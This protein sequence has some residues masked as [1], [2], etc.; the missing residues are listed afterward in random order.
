MNKIINF[1]K[2]NIKISDKFF[3][4]MK[5]NLDFEDRKDEL[6]IYGLVELISSIEKKIY[7]LNK[8]IEFNKS[9]E[10][11]KKLSLI[12][13]EILK[14]KKFIINF[15]DK[16][17]KKEINHKKMNSYVELGNQIIEMD[18][19]ELNQKMKD[20]SNG[21]D[22]PKEI[23]KCSNEKITNIISEKNN[24]DGLKYRNIDYNIE[25]G[26]YQSILNYLKDFCNKKELLSERMNMMKEEKEILKKKLIE[27]ISKKESIEESSKIILFKF[28]NEEINL[29]VKEKIKDNQQ[30]PNNFLSSNIKFSE[31]NLNINLYELYTININNL[32]QE[33]SNQVISFFNSFCLKTIINSKNTF[34]NS[35]FESNNSINNDIQSFIISMSLGIKKEFLLFINSFQNIDDKYKYVN[36]FQK[37]INQFLIKLSKNI[38]NFL[39]Y[40]TNEQISSNQEYS[41]LI[42]SLSDNS[43]LITYLKL[44]IKKNYI[45]RIIQEDTNFLNNKYK[46]IEDSIKNDLFVCKEK[47]KELSEK[48]NIFKSKLNELGLEMDTL[49]LEKSNKGINPNSKENIYLIL[50]EKTN[51]LLENKKALNNNFNDNINKCEKWNDTI[52]NIIL[53][54]NEEIN[55]LQKKKKEIEEKI[56]KRNKIIMLEINKLKMLKKENLNKLRIKLHL[57]KEK[58]GNNFSSFDIFIEKINK[59]LLSTSQSLLH[60]NYNYSLIK[61]NNNYLTPKNKPNLQKEHFLIRKSYDFKMNNNKDSIFEKKNLTTLIKPINEIVSANIKDNYL[62]NEKKMHKTKSLKNEVKRILTPK[63]ISHEEILDRKSKSNYNELKGKFTELNKPF[64]CYFREYSSKNEIIFDPLYHSKLIEK[65]PFFFKLV[66]L[67]LSFIRYSI[68]LNID[69]KDGIISKKINMKNIKATIINNNIKYIIKIHQRHKHKIKSEKYFDLQKFISSNIF[70][71]IPFDLNKKMLAFNNRFFNFSVLFTDKESNNKRIEFIFEEYEEM[72][73]WINALNYLIRIKNL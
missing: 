4:K 37:L 53:L 27:Y 31:D 58:Y 36:N 29:N 28:M 38:I 62:S 70:D 40:Y 67:K 11:F 63:K 23:Y 69:S 41:N 7:D 3:L 44:L 61:D 45:E 43:F 46:V 73:I 24:K 48:E 2:N 72:K 65:E 8:N 20:I 42:E 50:S 1:D 13:E 49:H 51:K 9:N 18:L 64:K 71:D 55:N 6:D 47:V 35:E 5:A 19:E 17:E 25:I 21:K 32:S 57:F 26:I 16:K 68:F 12:E 22:N 52:N 60:K 59:S 66:F 10:F 15:N 56:S 39:E 33:I 34:L 54:K 30:L 14:R